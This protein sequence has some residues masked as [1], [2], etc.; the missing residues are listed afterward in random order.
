MTQKRNVSVR[1]RIAS[2]VTAGAVLLLAGCGQGGTQGAVPLEQ[3]CLADT[4]QTLHLLGTVPSCNADDLLCRA[5]C[6]TGDAG[7]CLGMAYAAEKSKNAEAASLYHRGCLLGA[8]N[9]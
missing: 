6:F 2:R 7:S 8:A 3:G 5:K 9:A 4:V 1:L